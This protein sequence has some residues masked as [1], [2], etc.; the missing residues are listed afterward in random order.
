M[1]GD[2][3]VLAG[4]S[5]PIVFIPGPIC[6]TS[7]ANTVGVRL[8]RF[9]NVSNPGIEKWACINSDFRAGITF[10]VP[11]NVEKDRGKFEARK[12]A[13]PVLRFRSLRVQERTA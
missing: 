7:Q 9:G 13:A 10:G 6:N 4:Y 3:I 11:L 12:E 5:I 8:V 1:F 2:S